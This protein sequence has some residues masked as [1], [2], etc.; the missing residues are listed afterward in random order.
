MRRRWFVA[1]ISGWALACGGGGGGQPP[2]PPASPAP[3]A[4]DVTKDPPAHVP[5]ADAAAPPGVTVALFEEDGAECLWQV[6]RVP[7]GTPKVLARLPGRCPMAYRVS[8]SA[9][10]K[11][12]LI[13]TD[14]PKGWMVD[15]AT[16]HAEPLPAAPAGMEDATFVGNEV[17][18][19]GVLVS[20]P[21]DGKLAFEGKDYPFDPE[22]GEA[23]VARTWRLAGSSW[24][25]VETA[26]TQSPSPDAGPPGCDQMDSFGGG[27]ELRPGL[28][29]FGNGEHVSDAD[30]AA[31]SALDGHAD[32][33]WATSGGDH[34]FAV[35]EE[36][37]EGPYWEG[38]IYL[39]DGAGWKRLPGDWPGFEPAGDGLVMV[40]GDEGV[41]LVSTIDGSVVWR[42]DSIPLLWPAD[43]GIQP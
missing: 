6:G 31:L 20:E 14:G 26:M 4:T 32:A 16:A 7:G 15:L 5:P 29:G 21:T 23:A 18:G 13:L 35:R 9:D 28:A 40:S 8:P 1:V 10:W 27:N 22:N 41:H 2:P 36:W 38:P 17:R 30:A 39:R 42:S 19:C 37:G 3:T 11:R 43:A 24:D 33:T 34:P 12:A 25:V